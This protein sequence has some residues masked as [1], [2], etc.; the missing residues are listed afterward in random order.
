[1]KS[2]SAGIFFLGLAVAAHAGGPNYV[3]GS[4]YFN[5]SVLG[6]PI[7]WAN[8]Q[9]NYYV[10]QGP[11]S[12][13]I[14]NQQATAMVDAAAALWSAVP[15]AG[16]TLTDMGSLAENVSG[17]NTVA[18]NGVFAAPAD[19]TPNATGF[20]V[21]VIYDADGSVENLLFGPGT[22]GTT[23]CET[24]GVMVVI[25]H[26]NADAT[27]GHA[28][29]ILN[30]LCT[31]TANQIEMM[32]FELERAW[33]M[34]LNLGFAQV[35]PKAAAEGNSAQLQAWPVMQPV[36]GACGFMG[37]TCIPNPGQL[38]P[39]DIAAINRLYPITSANLAQFPGKQVTAAGTVSIRGVINFH[40][41][42]G[43]QGVNV[44]ATPLDVNGNPIYQ[45]T[46]TAVSGA[47]F[48]GNHGSEVTG[49]T[50]AND[51]PLSQ[52]GSNDAVAQ[53][54]FDLSG[55]PLPPGMTS[56]AYQL[57][58]EAIS[59]DYFQQ[60]T[61]G[62]YYDGAPDPSGTLAP[63]TTNTLA[64]GGSQ[65]I[66]VNVADSATGEYVGV[67]GAEDA[68]A[69]LP[70]SGMW[71]GRLTAISQTDW[72]LFSVLGNRTFTIVAQAVDE[73]GSPSARKAMPAIGVWNASDPVGTA[74]DGMQPGPDGNVA[75]ETWFQ[76]STSSAG[77]LRMGIADLRGDGR[78][79]YAY[80]GWVLYAG[81]IQPPRLPASGG[82]IVIQGMGFRSYDTVMINGQAAQVTGIS[83]TEITAI[84][85][86]A[87]SGVTGSVDVEVDDL[88]QYYASAVIPGGISYDAATGDTLTI[89]TAPSGT[90]PIG[91]PLAFTVQAFGANTLPAGGVTVMYSVTGGSATLGCGLS[92]CSV[93]TAGDGT[94]SITVTAL[95]TATAVVR[96][97]LVNNA[98]VQT[99]FNGG[100]PPSITAL[101]QPL[102]LADNGATI[103]WPVQVIALS[104]GGAPVANQS[105][106]WQTTAGNGITIPG[107]ATVTTNASGIASNTL[108][109]GPLSDGEQ[110][111]AQ[112]CINGTGQC[113]T[114][115]AVGADW[116]SATLEA[117]SGTA[118]TVGVGTA[119][120]QIV[121]RVLDKNG[122][123]MAGGIVSLYQ[124]VYAWAPPCATHGICAQAELLASETATATSGID[125]T[126]TFAPASIAGVATNVVALAA[127]GDT[128]TLG[129][130]IVTHP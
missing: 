89:V 128:A 44:L 67:T 129:V 28:F 73:T 31:A 110:S 121:L 50:G 45:Y 122:N 76:V 8:G 59:E 60:E 46:V 37:G 71:A 100:T 42:T 27:I 36:M 70:A 21:G 101:T 117:L 22:S 74:A 19:V 66:T 102:S 55:I 48:S 80:N 7:H 82:P 17:A 40:D 54:T 99:Q 2:L 125:G 127:T 113:A 94:A 63:V 24:T 9:V 39:D 103:A 1:M 75:G 107:S 20:P 77:L 5:S 62:P 41:G 13:T 126:V 83:P 98:S 56:A 85:P 105:V 43:M 23:N 57:T 81:S 14:T 3:A 65:A 35:Y 25:D 109:V 32:N 6:Q 49:W 90:V 112:A 12:S 16:V 51:V 120:A 68:P 18:N 47:L 30:G 111:T 26:F 33:G 29:M 38:H 10:D 11:L 92:V 130:G 104:G 124:A 52:W 116:Q 91:V 84:A 78:P 72:F 123:P 86:A 115:T 118:Q 69:P 64:A 61:V 4:T 53:G 79:D 93:T 58:F 96:A 119:P 87:G 106:T 108:T 95:N 15:T 114:F 97:S 34:I 88:T